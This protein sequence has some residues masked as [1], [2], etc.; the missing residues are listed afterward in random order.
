VARGAGEAVGDSCVKW[1]SLS[2]AAYLLTALMVKEP[3]LELLRATFVPQIDLS[4]GFFYIITGVLGTTISP[5]MFFWQASEEIEEER[6]RHLI[7][8]L[9]VVSI[10]RLFLR[11][12]RIDTVLGMV[13]SEI[14]TWCMIV[15][16]GSVLHKNGITNVGTAADAARTLEPLVHT[17]PH[18]GLLTKVIFATGVVGLG[19]LAIPV[20][21]G[22]ASYALCELANW[23]EGLD[24]KLSKARSFYGVIIVATLLGLAMNYLG[25]DPIKALV[26]TAVFNGVAAVPLIFLIAKVSSSEKI[27]GIYRSGRLSKSLLWLTFAAMAAAAAVM[28]VSIRGS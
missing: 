27:M 22:S 28:F 20:L 23:A 13:A 1:L 12:L 7:D 6:Q 14:A 17:F 21:A 25:I 5:Y 8:S 10:N 3:W 26:F 2:L 24:L 11:D 4:F 19:L 16:G 15:V 9:G 18:A